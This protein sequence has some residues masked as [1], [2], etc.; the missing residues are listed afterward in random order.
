[1]KN[2]A[3]LLIYHANALD[4][5]S[6]DLLFSEPMVVKCFTVGSQEQTQTTG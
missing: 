5:D 6:G 2:Y 3:K 1:M 4:M